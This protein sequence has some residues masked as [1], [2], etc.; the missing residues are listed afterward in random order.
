MA[1]AVGGARDGVCVLVVAADDGVE[2]GEHGDR[3]LGAAALHAGLDAGEAVA[4][5]EFKAELGERVLHLLRGLELLEAEFGFGKDGF[6]DRFDLGAVGGD[7]FADFLLDGGFVHVFR[8]PLPGPS[9][10]GTCGPLL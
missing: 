8:G 2:L 1:A 10:V 9:L 4:G 3:A 5:R 7:G 6:G